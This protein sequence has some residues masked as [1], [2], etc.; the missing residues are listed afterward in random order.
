VERAA[1]LWR[2]NL[3]AYLDTKAENTG[4]TYRNV[5]VQTP[6]WA[7][8]NADI[9]LCSSFEHELTQMAF[10]DA[11]PSVKVVLSHPVTKVHAQLAAMAREGREKAKL[12]KEK[13]DKE[14]ASAA[15]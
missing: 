3:V 12:E 2:V 7:A 1:E 15:A 6:E 4:S 8:E 10:L 9:V 13:A 14:K 5:T 11:M